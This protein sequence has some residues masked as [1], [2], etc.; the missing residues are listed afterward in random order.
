MKS[1]SGLGQLLKGRRQALALSQRALAEKL[2]VKAA[3]VAYLEAGRR[4]PSLPLLKRLA[5]TLGLDSQ[6]LFLLAHPE[7]KA[8]VSPSVRP[9]SRKRPEQ[10]WRKLISDRALLRRYQVTR[11][12]LRA[13]KQ[14]SLFGYVLSP[15]EFLAI[16]TLIRRPDEG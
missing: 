11:R 7:A 5:N 1:K 14:L 16:L 4:N 3:H 6:Q 15:R 9:A 12:E 10:G 2:G 13:L 8:L